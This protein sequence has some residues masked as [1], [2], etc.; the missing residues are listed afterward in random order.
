ML[1]AILFDSDDRMVAAAPACDQLPYG[2]RFWTEFY[3]T[4]LSF[5]TGRHTGYV[6]IDRDDLLQRLGELAHDPTQLAYCAAEIEQ[7]ALQ[8]EIHTRRAA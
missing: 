1:Y 6:E 7:L 8:E 3:P 4:R 2:D 5:H